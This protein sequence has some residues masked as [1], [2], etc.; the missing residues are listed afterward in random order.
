MRRKDYCLMIL[1][2]VVHCLVWLTVSYFSD[3]EMPTSFYIP[4]FFSSTA[5]GIASYVFFNFYKAHRV[6]QVFL[7]IFVLLVSCLLSMDLFR[8]LEIRKALG[9]VFPERVFLGENH[10]AMF[11]MIAYVFLL[12]CSFFLGFLAFLI[13]KRKKTRDVLREPGHRGQFCVLT[14]A[15]KRPN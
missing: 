8:F 14:R 13:I 3:F 5:I 10:G 6:R 7:R 11:L 2:D 12:L 15:S 1:A 4:I 9:A